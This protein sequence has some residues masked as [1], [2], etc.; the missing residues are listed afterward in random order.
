M[1]R[2]HD[3]REA[4]PVT[5]ISA[6]HVRHAG[7]LARFGSSQRSRSPSTP[8]ASSLASS[9]S[10]RP[11]MKGDDMPEREPRSAENIANQYD[12]DAMVP[13]DA[14]DVIPWPEA[15]KRL[16]EGR[17]FW[18]ATTRPDG[19][20]HVR[21]VLWPFWSTGCFT[22]RPTG[23]PERRGTSRQT[24]A[25]RSLSRRMRSTSSSREPQHP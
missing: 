18:W 5:F 1:A 22:P 19:R 10:R 12:D 3:G 9:R 7:G 17:S 20:P 21:P 2:L 25:S 6:A 13:S 4:G 15:R 14:D 11:K 23:A 16:A 8:R 24:R